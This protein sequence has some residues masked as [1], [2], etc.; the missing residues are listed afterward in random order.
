MDK[1]MEEFLSITQQ[2]DNCAVKFKI[3]QNKVNELK[4]G[5]S[6]TNAQVNELNKLEKEFKKLNQVTFELR[7]KASKL[8]SKRPKK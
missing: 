1:I 3:L 4:A 5:F 8:K 6:N 7:E 2:L